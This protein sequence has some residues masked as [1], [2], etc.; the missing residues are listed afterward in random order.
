MSIIGSQ[1]KNFIRKLAKLFYFFF[2]SISVARAVCLSFGFAI[3]SGSILL[4]IVE[5]DTIDPIDALYLSASAFCVTGL[6]PVEISKL[7]TLGQILIISY[8]QMG[9]LGVI[10]FT[11]LI[12]LLVIGGLS[13]NAKLR[14]LVKGVLDAEIRPESGKLISESDKVWRL[15]FSIFKITI[16]IELLGA[17]A[18]YYAFPNETPGNVSRI[19]LAL[20]TSISAFNNAGFSLVDSAEFL[21][22]SP[23]S[24]YILT[25]LIVMGGIGY[26]VIIFIEK[27]I[28]EV[29]HKIVSKFEV[30]GETHLM[31]RAIR[32]EEPSSVYL[33]MT[34]I[35]LW[36]EF[37]IEDYNKRLFGE[38]NIIQTKIIFY[39][40]LIL[41]LGGTIILF[42]LE[43]NNEKTI[44][45][46]EFTFHEKF[47]NI[48][49]L[50]AS[51]RTAGFAT[52][53]TANLFDSSIVLVCILMFIGGGPQGTAGGIKI[54][55]FSILVK[56]LNNVITSLS[57]VD[58]FGQTISKTSVAMSIRLYFLGT[59]VLAVTVFLLTILRGEGKQL[60]KIVFEV[61]SAFST[62]GFS[63][64]LTDKINDFEKV[65]YSLLMYVG[66]IGVFTVLI[67]ITGN[68]ATS[69]IGEMDEA[70]KIQVG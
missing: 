52:F 58:F 49:F 15:I 63:L 38:S 47:A 56:Y 48:L 11:V 51:S 25:M 65:I 8:V 70:V 13:R 61:I 23:L 4:Y 40:T 67:A 17:I 2:E 60:D 66:R 46:L 62:V 22:K 21:I 33:T 9:G 26:P 7:S 16:T 1:L 69:Q 27:S 54:T 5:I 39:G 45:S 43:F 30:W 28:L 24:L 31:T 14:D 64:G 37:R 19:F 42:L 29:F 53:P 55:T 3:L 57:K 68:P 35:S 36:T 34:K 18:L 32:G 41:L 44:G 50:S 59:T 10:V 6:A 20:F 12:G